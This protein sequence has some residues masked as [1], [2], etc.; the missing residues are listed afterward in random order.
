MLTQFDVVVKSPGISAYKSPVPQAL[1]AGVKF[2]SASALWFAENP[3]ARTICVTGT[4]GKSTVT[5]LIAHILRKSGKCVALAGNIGLPLL[6]LDHAP[7]T[8][9]WWV[10][11]LSSF[12]TRDFDGAPTIALITNLYEEHLDWHSTREN[13]MADK[14]AIGKNAACLVVAD[15]PEL[16]AQTGAHP[17]RYA[18]GTAQG[19]HVAG[20]WIWR[21]DDRVL[22]LSDVP[23]PGMHNARNVCACLAAI[24]C[25]GLDSRLLAK[26]VSSFRAL[27]HRLQS[28]GRRDDCE[29]VN[30]SIATTPYATV[31]ALRAFSGRDVVVLVGGFDRGVDWDVFVEHVRLQPPRAIVTMGAN[32]ARIAAQLAGIQTPGF[33]LRSVGSLAQALKQAH[34]LAA[35]GSIVLMSPGAPSFDAFSDYAQRGREFARLAG[36][37]VESAQ[38]EGLGIA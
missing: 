18:F 15:Q 19:W 20:D 13:Y 27:P 5:A 34:A 28:L 36:L 31:E 8:V 25:A 30:D 38:I 4:K 22:A 12:Q 35:P 11:E 3:H 7:R 6:E 1:E 33:A 32:G 23:L 26:H 14:L 21:G 24:E 2:T 37:E 9:D 17:N 29:Y 16:M 10:I